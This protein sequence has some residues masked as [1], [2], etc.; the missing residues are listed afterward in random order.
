MGD[1]T[2]DGLVISCLLVLLGLV[3]GIGFSRDVTRADDPAPFGFL[4]ACLFYGGLA[5]AAGAVLD[6]V[7]AYGG[8]S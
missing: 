7:L 2:L 5:A 3:L 6:F 1:G 4:A 8:Q